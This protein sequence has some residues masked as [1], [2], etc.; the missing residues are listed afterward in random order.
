MSATSTFILHNTEVMFISVQPS[1]V[2]VSRGLVRRTVASGAHTVIPIRCTKMTYR[3]SA[4]VRVTKERSL[5]MIRSTTRNIS[6][7]CGKGT[8]NAVKSF[9]YCD[10]RR[11]GGCAVKRNNTV[12]FGKS[13]C[14]RGT[15]VL[16]RGKASHD[17]F[18]HN[19]MSGC[20]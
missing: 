7:C 13:R 17:G 15:R 16:E 11:A 3:V 18:F 4:V 1:A 9:N 6:T 19:R 5:G 14:L 10:F 8:L 12:L 2:G 20:H